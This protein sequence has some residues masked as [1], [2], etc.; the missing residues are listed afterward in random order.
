[1]EV[2]LNKKMPLLTQVLKLCKTAPSLYKAI[3]TNHR[4]YY[5]C[6]K[7]KSISVQLL[8][9]RVSDRNGLRSR[10][11]KWRNPWRPRPDLAFEVR[12]ETPNSIFSIHSW[13]KTI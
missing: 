7:T 10:V 9:V 8:R 2:E 11:T 4:R 5:P 6:R 1:L 3:N 13:S 12:R